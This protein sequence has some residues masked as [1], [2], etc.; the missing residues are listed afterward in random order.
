[1]PP[2]DEKTRRFSICACFFPPS[3]S[4]G[5]LLLLLGRLLQSSD[6]ELV[7][8]QELAGHGPQA[9][10]FRGGEG[11]V[12]LVDALLEGLLGKQNALDLLLLLLLQHHHVLL[13]LGHR[14]FV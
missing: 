14:L 2:K 8:V 5:E 12:G 1:M 9:A 6:H 11:G 13:Q 4:L 3:A 10:L 7:G